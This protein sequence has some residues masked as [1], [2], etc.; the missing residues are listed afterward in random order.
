MTDPTS[1]LARG[2][3]RLFNISVIM[4]LNYERLSLVRP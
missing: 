2:S 4:G 1:V 3:L